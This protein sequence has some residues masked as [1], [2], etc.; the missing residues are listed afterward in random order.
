[1][2]GQEQGTISP[3]SDDSNKKNMSKLSLQNSFVYKCSLRYFSKLKKKIINFFPQNQ[4]PDQVNLR[5]DEIEIDLPSREEI[6]SALK[7]LKNNKAQ[8]QLRPSC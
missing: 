6:E 1:V 2:S 8:N 3:H 5:D 4:P 7:Y